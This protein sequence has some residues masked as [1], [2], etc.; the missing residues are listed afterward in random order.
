MYLFKVLIAFKPK[1]I[2][3]FIMINTTIRKINSSYIKQKQ[4]KN[5]T[6]KLKWQGFD[7]NIWNIV[8]IIS[9]DNK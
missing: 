1:F 4:H 9:I 7:N 3:Q 6:V 5:N 2:K 8:L